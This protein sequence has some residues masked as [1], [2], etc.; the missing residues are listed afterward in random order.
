MTFIGGGRACIGFKFSQLEM[1]QSFGVLSAN[2]II[3][4]T[5]TEVVLTLLINSFKFTPSDKQIIWKM[6]GI[7][8]PA[9]AGEPDPT[10]VQLPMVV[11][12]AD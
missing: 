6:H 5:Y 9:V 11:Q 2:Q 8:S 12:M 10:K 3:S 1:S 4:Y 7:T